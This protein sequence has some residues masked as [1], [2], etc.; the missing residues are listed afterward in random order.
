VIAAYPGSKGKPNQEPHCGYKTG[1]QRDIEHRLDQAGNRVSFLPAFHGGSLR[2][3]GFDR[4]GIVCKWAESLA[5][6]QIQR[7]TGWVVSD[8]PQN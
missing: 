5:F 6:I 7:I 8:M 2:A 1:E 3:P 4:E